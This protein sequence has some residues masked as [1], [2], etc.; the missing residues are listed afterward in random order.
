MDLNRG[1]SLVVALGYVA[2]SYG[3]DGLRGALLS[4]LPL[5]ILLTMIWCPEPFAEFTGRTGWTH[6]ARRSPAGAVRLLAW[7]LL[8]APSIVL[9][10]AAFR[11]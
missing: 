5:S 3:D 4:M 2:L 7:A 8:L 11:G 6:I 9:A 10:V 1:F